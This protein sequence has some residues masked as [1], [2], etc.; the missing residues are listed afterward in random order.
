[1]LLTE[2]V[3]L[4]YFLIISRR[5]CKKKKKKRGKM[6]ILQGGRLLLQIAQLVIFFESD[7]DLIISY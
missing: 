4:S 1:M 7:F 3:V 5:L 6:Q 2:K